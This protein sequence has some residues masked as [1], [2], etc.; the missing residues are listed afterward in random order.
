M[1]YL[2]VTFDTF[3]P[4]TNVT[5]SDIYI[6]SRTSVKTESKPTSEILNILIGGVNDYEGMLMDMTPLVARDTL[7]AFLN[8]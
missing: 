5:N 1:G 3:Y 7:F 2:T 8:N 6:S 4:W